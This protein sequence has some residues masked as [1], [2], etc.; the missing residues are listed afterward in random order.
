MQC[1]VQCKEAEENKLRAGGP[2]HNERGEY[3]R[4]VLCKQTTRN[5]HPSYSVSFLYL[6]LADNQTTNKKHPSYS[7][8]FL[9][10]C[11]AASDSVSFLYLCLA[12]NQ[13]TNKEHPSYSVLLIFV[14][15]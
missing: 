13:T 1:K 3:I 10:L 8:S 6:C 11:R 15:G 5:K 9:Y 12:E 4:E 2:S 7:V 14:S